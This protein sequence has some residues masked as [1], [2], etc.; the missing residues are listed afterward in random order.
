MTHEDRWDDAGCT[1]R[2]RLRVAQSGIGMAE[3]GLL[4]LSFGGE[5]VA[6]KCF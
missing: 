2:R 3:G 1:V 5:P 4:A 6:P